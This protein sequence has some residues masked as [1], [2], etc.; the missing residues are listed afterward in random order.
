MLLD[1]KDCWIDVLLDDTEKDKFFNSIASLQAFLLRDVVYENIE[2]LMN[3][4][5]S[6]KL[7]NP[8]YIKVE[9]AD[10]EVERHTVWDIIKRI[11]E[12]GTDVVRL[13]CRLYPLMYPQERTFSISSS[14]ILER[15]AMKKVEPFREPSESLEQIKKELGVLDESQNKVDDSM[16]LIKKLYALERRTKLI[17]VTWCTEPYQ[18]D[19]TNVKAQLMTSIHECI[20]TLNAEV[21]AHIYDLIK[22]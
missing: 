13:E 8:F 4:L 14:V 10:A 1:N 18:F 7:N 16:K 9:L 6:C 11:V 22:K 3:E 17:R 12:I 5:T 2:G 15:F 21:T 19:F 20:R